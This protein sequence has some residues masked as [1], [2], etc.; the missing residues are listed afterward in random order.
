MT[1]GL[2]LNPNADLFPIRAAHPHRTSPSRA[3][4]SASLPPAGKG[5]KSITAIV[6]SVAADFASAAK[7]KGVEATV[8]RTKAASKRIAATFAAKR[9]PRS[10][11]PPVCPAR[12]T[13]AAPSPSAPLRRALNLYEE[14]VSPASLKLVKLKV[15]SKNKLAEILTSQP[16]EAF[17]L[18]SHFGDLERILE[19][20]S[21]AINKNKAEFVKKA[22]KV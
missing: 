19:E 15:G 6:A 1:D 12:L 9:V 13:L 2:S 17:S 10:T 20:A 4:K 18:A 7:A 22:G 5:D 3:K 8:V 11:T 16:C 14:L 21:D